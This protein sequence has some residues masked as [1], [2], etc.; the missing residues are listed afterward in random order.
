MDF[1]KFDFIIG[2]ELHLDDSILNAEVFP[3]HYTVYRRDINRYGGVFILAKHNMLSS[4]LQSSSS[5]KLIWVDTHL[6]R[7]QD[8]V[9][10]CLYC[11]PIVHISMLEH[12][13][14]SLHKVKSAY[15]TAKI[16]LGDFN[17]PGINWS[18]SS[19][20]E[21]YVSTSFR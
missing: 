8:I 13:Q 20:T 5:V 7:T 10:G 15:C 11:P 21:L 16:F 3:S 6:K 19:I 9:L 18:N 4:F 1:H 2:T 17:S 14:N 12:L